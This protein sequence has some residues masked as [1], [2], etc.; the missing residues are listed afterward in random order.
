M[1]KL[2]N[3]DYFGKFYKLG[4]NLLFIRRKLA[5]LSNSVTNNFLMEH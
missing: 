3:V 4:E 2:G 5:E 1:C